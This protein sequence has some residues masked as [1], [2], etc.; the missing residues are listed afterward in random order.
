MMNYHRH[1]IIFS[2]LIWIMSISTPLLAKEQK[3]STQL[4]S[5]SEIKSVVKDYIHQ[6]TSDLSG[7][8][9]IKIE[10]ID[11]RITLPECEQLESFLPTGSRLWAITSIGVRC[12]EPTSWTI[13]VKANIQVLDNVVHIAR[14]LNQN[15]PLTMDDLLLKKVDLTQVQKGVFTDPEQVVG[16]ISK[17]NISAG[18]PILNHMLRDP[19][20][21]LRGQKVTLQVKGRGF[22][23]NSDGQALADAAE[24]QV[25]QVRNHAKRI[26]SGIARHNAIVE[27]L[28]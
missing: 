21:I 25:V 3:L 24:G 19:Y 15:Q 20:V 26:I 14:P 5:I 9:S 2:G 16:K 23:V 13:Y 28:P 10:D 18:Q 22:S 4:Q 27:V 1:L 17:T 8:V 11:R 6:N 12:T 7:E